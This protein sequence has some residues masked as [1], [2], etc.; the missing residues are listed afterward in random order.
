[1]S[2][3]RIQCPHCHIEFAVPR[4]VREGNDPLDSLL[5]SDCPQC[6]CLLNI[7][8]RTKDSDVY[9]K[10][11]LWKQTYTPRDRALVEQLMSDVDCVT[12]R[13]RNFTRQ[14]S[15]TWLRS[16][17]APPLVHILQ[18]RLNWLGSL[19]GFCEM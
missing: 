15:D 3:T 6:M 18:I 12:L 9:F 14:V 17:T 2:T 19:L 10:Q 1:M 11:A 4:V 8:T 7:G 16:G 13:G 5:W